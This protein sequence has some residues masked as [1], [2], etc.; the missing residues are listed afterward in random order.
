M[1]HSSVPSR[2][3]RRAQ[4]PQSPGRM[5]GPGSASRVLDLATGSAFVQLN[6]PK[7]QLSIPAQPLH[8]SGAD[9]G[10]DRKHLQALSPQPCCPSCLALPTRLLPPPGLSF[11]PASPA[12]HLH[13]HGNLPEITAMPP[14]GSPSPLSP[15]PCIPSPVGACLWLQVTFLS[16]PRGAEGNSALWE[17]AGGAGIWGHVQDME[18]PLF[19]LAGYCMTCGQEDGMKGGGNWEQGNSRSPWLRAAPR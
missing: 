13:V 14:L 9:V 6:S 1:E 4:S 2:G 7:S 10:P 11:R 5:S 12:N 17:G 18:T 3:C 19:M 8:P 15:V 16:N